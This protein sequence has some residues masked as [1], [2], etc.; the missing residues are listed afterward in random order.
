MIFI[1]LLSLFDQLHSHECR[2]TSSLTTRPPASVV[3]DQDKTEVFAVD[4]AG[5]LKACF[6]LALRGLR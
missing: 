6:G 1:L 3:A 5:Q 2:R 4:L